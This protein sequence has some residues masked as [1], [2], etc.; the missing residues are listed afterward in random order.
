[1]IL[2][3]LEDRRG[4]DESFARSLNLLAKLTV[5][6]IAF[7]KICIDNV[8]TPCLHYEAWMCISC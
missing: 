8:N 5:E 2:E 4:W 1:M 3:E 6:A 7:S